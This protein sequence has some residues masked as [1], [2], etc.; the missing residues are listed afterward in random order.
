MSRRQVHLISKAIA[1]PR[2]FEILQHIAAG[3]SCTACT[4]LRAAFPISAPT[5]SHHLKELESA[6]LI[7]SSKQGKFVSARFLRDTWKAYLKDLRQL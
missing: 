4:D 1:D 3:K 2:R 6:G 7:E 5:L